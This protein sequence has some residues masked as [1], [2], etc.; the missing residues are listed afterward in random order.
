MHFLALAAAGALAANANS[1]TAKAADNALAATGA[2]ADVQSCWLKAYGRGAGSPVSSCKDGEDKDGALCYPECKDG[3]DG[4]GPVCWS[5]CP[6]R[7][8]DD[9]AFCAKP[10]SYGRGVG[11][12]SKCSNCAKCLGLYYK[13]CGDGFKEAGCNIC[14][15]K[16]P[17]GMSDIG[18]SCAKNSYGRGAGTSLS[19]KDGE[20]KDAGLCYPACTNG[21]EGIGP[22]CWGTCPPGTSKCGAL[23]LIN[24][25]SCANYVAGNF[26]DMAELAFS[27]ASSNVPGTVISLVNVA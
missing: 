17:D 9:G 10:D 8:R 7:Y 1:L 16:C 5:A 22:V 12:I 27:M 18:V 11:K 24:S 20:E 21:T 4:V 13:K 3:Y 25:D 6:D 19:C 23:C 14:S 2:L 15:P 26:L